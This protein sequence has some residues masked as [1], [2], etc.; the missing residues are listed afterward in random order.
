[1]QRGKERSLGLE[2]PSR[3]LV[4]GCKE[5]TKTF[6]TRSKVSDASRISLCWI[7]IIKS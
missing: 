2:S 4:I 1:M 6:Y 7:I 5:S 3:L